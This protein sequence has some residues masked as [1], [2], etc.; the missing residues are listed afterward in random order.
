MSSKILKLGT[1]AIPKI[2]SSNLMGFKPPLILDTYSADLYAAYSLRKLR[3]GYSG[4]CVRVRRSS[5]NAE[6]D[7]GFVNDVVDMASII[8]FCGA[9]NGFVT[10]WYDQSGLSKDVIQ[11]PAGNQPQIIT[12]GAPYLVGGKA[13][14]NFANSHLRKASETGI[15]INNICSI[16]LVSLDGA[17]SYGFGLN[18]TPRYYFPNVS[19]SW[20]A[21]SYNSSNTFANTGILATGARALLTGNANLT[22]YNLRINASSIGSTAVFSGNINNIGIG[23]PNASLYSTGKFFEFIL[24]SASQLA[25]LTDL[26]TDIND[27]YAVY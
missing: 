8:T 21:V 17:G 27:Y 2:G 22:N 13:Y 26:E 20:Q 12:S 14:L 23:T 9:G 10:T 19:G 6:Q 3:N 25:N 5:D 11:A 15:N 24:Y 4:N 1:F 7:F 18:T 16:A